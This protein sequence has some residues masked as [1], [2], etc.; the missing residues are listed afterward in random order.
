VNIQIPHG[1]DVSGMKAT[2]RQVGGV[3][4]PRALSPAHDPDALLRQATTEI[5]LDHAPSAV[6][7]WAVDDAIGSYGDD[8]SIGVMPY[9]G[10]ALP[11]LPAQRE[12]SW[13]NAA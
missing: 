10:L 4:S 1:R 3:P 11:I 6:L 8:A 5:H 2:E 9:A 12:K 13:C 7:R